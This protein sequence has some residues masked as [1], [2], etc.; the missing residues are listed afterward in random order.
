M[1]ERAHYERRE[2]VNASADVVFDFIDDH[3]QFSA[4]MG[5]SSWMTGGGKMKVD[6]DEQRGRPVG[7]HI[8]MTG[9]ILGVEI[10]LDEVVTQHER[11]ARKGWATV[12]TPHLTV[13]GSNTMG[14]HLTPHGDGT[15]VRVFI[16]YDLPSGTVT[17][18]L[19]R[20]F[21]S[22]YAKWCVDQMLAGVVQNFRTNTDAPP[23]IAD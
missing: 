12:G 13:I 8:R 17:H 1:S 2:Q 23:G 4:H 14:A 9:S 22:A 15:L 10:G 21:G 16:D 6:M 7:S 11:P 20:L 19:G 18:E 5:Q 3:E